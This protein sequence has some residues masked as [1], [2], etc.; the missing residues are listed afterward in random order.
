MTPLP[1]AAGS[2]VGGAALTIDGLTVTYHGRDAA[3]HALQG[4]SLAVGTGEIVTVVGESG[5]GKSTLAHA[6][7]GLLDERTTTVHG[8]ASLGG[9]ELLGLP[10]PQRRA[11][12][13]RDLAMVF[14]E[15][16]AALNPS[17]RVGRQ[18]AEA[19]TV[20]QPKVGERQAWSRAV[21]LLERLGLP[22][23]G[24]RAR[25]Y[26]HELSGGMQQRVCLA[27][28]L[29]NQPTVLLAD[30]PTTALDASAQAGVLE[31]L[32]EERGQQGLAVL[33]VTHDLGVVA[34]I[35][36]R[37][38]VMYAGRVVEDGPVA[39]VLHSPRH[40]Y[41]VALVEAAPSLA[42]AKGRSSSQLEGTAPDPRIVIHGCAFRERCWLSSDACTF[43]Q[44]APR[45]VGD[46]HVAACVHTDRVPEP[47]R[48]RA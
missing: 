45:V 28:A 37:V 2:A 39:R 25:R 10:E 38:V 27:M 13:G 4:V 17:M 9:T 6:V 12:R 42:R 41:T 15:P 48:W 7:M 34:A 8:R 26:P 11:L 29:A 46:R 19:I 30:E 24:R 44:P 32:R 14:Q 21:A 20:H 5:S 18:V 16:A 43:H 23:A 31:L 22:E 36:D 35:A 33:L 1:A 47:V 3:V 40:P